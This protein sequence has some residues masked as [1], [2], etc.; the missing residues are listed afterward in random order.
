MTDYVDDVVIPYDRDLGPV[1]V[2]NRSSHNTIVMKQKLIPLIVLG[3]ALTACGPSPSTGSSGGAAVEIKITGLVLNED[4]PVTK[5]KIEAQD[6]KGATVAK[7]EVSGD[8]HYSLTLP[9][10]T[11]Y[12]V[13]LSAQPEAEPKPLKAVV[14]SDLVSEQDIS[15]VTTIVVDTAMSLG[16]LTEANLA[17]A[18]GAAISQRKSSGGSGSSS[19]FKGD[20]TKQYGGWH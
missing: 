7:T 8:G 20:P 11:A 6:G 1:L 13:V 4:N 2:C 12:P 3:L 18:A 14:T 17:K 5:A 15:T 19:G 10:G 9:A 16:G